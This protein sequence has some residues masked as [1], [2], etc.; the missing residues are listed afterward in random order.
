MSIC[1][2][3]RGLLNQ[4]CLK[5]T[6][7]EFVDVILHIASPTPPPPPPPPPV[8][9]AF[10]QA[11]TNDL[12]GGLLTCMIDYIR[13]VMQHYVPTSGKVVVVVSLLAAVEIP[14]LFSADAK[15]DVAVTTFPFH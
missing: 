14:H 2:S 3:R 15:R 9:V 13:S 1:I 6:K 8:Q 11:V 7:S 10:S 5:K 12:S 4:W